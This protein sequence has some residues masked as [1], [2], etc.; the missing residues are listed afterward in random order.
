MWGRP[1]L[2]IPRDNVRATSLPAFAYT[3]AYTCM[4]IHTFPSDKVGIVLYTG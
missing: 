2:H 1:E 3:Y 4:Y